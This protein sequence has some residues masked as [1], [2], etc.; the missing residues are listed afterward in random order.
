MQ[1]FSLG[2]V[3]C[4]AISSV[5]LRNVPLFK[6]LTVSACADVKPEAAAK[7]AKAFGVPALGVEDLLA[8]PDVD[9]VVNLTVPNAHYEVSMAALKAGKHL[10]TEKPLAARAALGRKLV[11]AAKKRGLA[12]ASAPDTFLGAAG[13]KARALIDHGAIGRPV[14]GA[15]FVLGHGMEHWHPNPD[16][17]YKPGGGPVL[18]LGPYY[19]TALINLLGPIARVQALTSIGE[20]KRLI[21]APGPNRGKTIKVETPTTALALLEFANGVHLVAGMSWDVWRH[22]A[23]PIE[24]HGT[25]GS[26]RLPDPNFF[27]GVVEVSKRGGEWAAHDTSADPFGVL[28]QPAAE[29]KVANYRVLGIADLAAAIR[30]KRPPRAGGDL[31]LHA[32]EAMEAILR[33]GAER[34][35]IRLPPADVRPAVLSEKEARALLA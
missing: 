35:A 4:G 24:I 18:D 14:A 22:G 20:A 1:T 6:G 7:Q 3:G 28:N 33:A 9:I 21:T 26:L 27:G 11:E 8:S 30:E 15:A 31:A 5:Y 23:A 13:R 17:F 12:I 2:V 19:I 25:E 10:F 34:R 29:P 32:L 16:F